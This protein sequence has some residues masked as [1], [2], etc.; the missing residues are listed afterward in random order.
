MENIDL[1]KLSSV[2]QR[3]V[4]SL[5]IKE[6]RGGKENRSLRKKDCAKNH[7]MKM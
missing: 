2:L 7:R 6:E 5:G 4:T 1:I 3:D